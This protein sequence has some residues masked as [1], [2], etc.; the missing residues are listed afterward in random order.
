MGGQQFCY[1][2]VSQFTYFPD[3]DISLTDAWWCGNPM[4]VCCRLQDKQCIDG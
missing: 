4:K 3:T 1:L 2:A